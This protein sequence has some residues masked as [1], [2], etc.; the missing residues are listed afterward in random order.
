MSGSYRGFPSGESANEDSGE[1]LAVSPEEKDFEH[2][3]RQLFEGWEGV[4]L[5][6][7]YENAEVPPFVTGKFQEEGRG[8]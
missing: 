2:D 5:R 3:P 4:S 8:R 6:V 7:L 1:V